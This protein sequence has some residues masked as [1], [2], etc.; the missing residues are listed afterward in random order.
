MNPS[1]KRVASEP[2]RPGSTQRAEE[3]AIWFPSLRA[4]VPKRNTAH[5]QDLAARIGQQL[6]C[7]DWSA[8]TLRELIREFTETLN[9][10]D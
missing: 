3:L 1:D 9:E 7:V 2:T 4:S 6:T 10:Q 8:F 5:L